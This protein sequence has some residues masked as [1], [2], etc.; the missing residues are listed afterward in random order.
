MSMGCQ[1]KSITITFSVERMSTT[2]HRMPEDLCNKPK[3]TKGTRMEYGAWSSSWPV[4][5]V[6][7]VSGI[8]GD[9][10][11]RRAG[12]GVEEVEG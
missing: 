5:C 8:L 6:D 12:E 10:G 2:V 1:T 11:A 4:Y 3:H 7:W 9:I